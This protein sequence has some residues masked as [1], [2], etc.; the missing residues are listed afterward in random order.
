MRILQLDHVALHVADVEISRQF[1]HQVLLL[2]ELPRPAFDFPG[3]W[4]RIGKEHELHLIGDRTQPVQSG[5]RGT[6]VAL[7]V[8]GLDRWEQHLDAVGATRLERKVRPDG[9]LQTFL[10]DPDGHW[11]ELNCSA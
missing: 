5:Y 10:V 3:A 2:E 8:D 1:Y 6:H 7:A 9:L 4:F 11:I